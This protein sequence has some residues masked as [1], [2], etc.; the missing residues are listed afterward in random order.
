MIEVE[1]AEKIL[2]GLAGP[3]VLRGHHARHG[4][5]QFAHPEHGRNAQVGVPDQPLGGGVR[6]ADLFRG[7]AEHDDFI[8]GLHVGLVCAGRPQRKQH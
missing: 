7:P 2:V 1:A 3:G 8:E 5:H 6:V 4:F